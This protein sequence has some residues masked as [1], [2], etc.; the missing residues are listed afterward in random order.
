MPEGDAQMFGRYRLIRL[1]GA[2]GMATV[3][4]AQ[5]IGPQGFVKPCVLKRIAEP[6]VDDDKYR[7]MFL[8][9]ARLSAL[10]NHPNVVQTFDFGEVEG[11]PYMAMELVD[12]VNLSVLCRGLAK[13]N[14]WIPLRA[15][16]E[17]CIQV[18]EALFYA[19]NIVGLDGRSLNLVHRDVSPQNVLVSRQ[20]GVKLADFGIARHD[21]RIE[22]TMGPTSKG[23]PGY[24][25]PEQAM[26]HATDG[27]ADLFA[28]G[29]VLCELIS[30][31][32]VNK[33]SEAPV[34]IID[35]S[36]R[37]QTLCEIRTEAPKSLIDL[38]VR[39]SDI[40]T[41]KR[42]A[43]AREVAELLRAEAQGLPTKDGLAGF[44]HRV[45]DRYFPPEKL[46]TAFHGSSGSF[47]QLDE[48]DDAARLTKSVSGDVL[49]GTDDQRATMVVPVEEDHGKTT[50][51]EP[52]DSLLDA[53][54]VFPAGP[55]D[56][57][58]DVDVVRVMWTQMNMVEEQHPAAAYAGWPTDLR[59]V[60]APPAHAPAEP[61]REAR[62][63]RPDTTV[64][65]EAGS[66]AVPERHLSSLPSLQFEPT[67][68]SAAPLPTLPGQS[69][70]SAFAPAGETQLDIGD[71]VIQPVAAPVP[72]REPP[73]P[74]PQFD[75]E[76]APRRI[77]IAARTQPTG[78]FDDIAE[79][80]QDAIGDSGVMSKILIAIAVGIG[81][82]L[83]AGAWI[84]MQPK[85]GPISVAG[86]TVAVTSDPAGAEILINGVGEGRHTP[87]SIDG[88]PLE[89]PIKMSVRLKGYLPVPATMRVVI[90]AKLGR[91]DAHFQ[92]ETAHVF[93]IETTPPGAQVE[94]N[95]V[96][97]STRTPL[98]LPEVP[99]GGTATITVSLDQ[100][101]SVRRLLRVTANAPTVIVVP[102]EKA[103]V[104]EIASD[105]PGAKVFVDG[106][107]VGLTPAYDIPVPSVSAFEV[108]LAR[109]G[110]K[111]WKRDFIGAQLEEHRIE[112]E[113]LDVPL[114]SLPL[115]REERA[116]AR[117]LDQ[118]L[119]R[120]RAD[121]RKAKRVLTH[122]LEEVARLRSGD[123]SFV[124]PVVKAQSAA[125]EAQERVDHFEMELD[126]VQS[127]VESFR[128]KILLRIEQAQ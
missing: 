57:P 23:K 61:Q 114:L 9:E 126:A 15:A 49:E 46:P 8:Q 92:M 58:A 95:G 12:G 18:C 120:H 22:V 83:L 38:T 85:Q 119:A 69:D 26:G 42:P 50:V 16:V 80:L 35:V 53:P 43:H 104:I 25:A 52:Q 37:I 4:L 36:E 118:A 65:P 93:T 60:L 5:Q 116:R 124:A 106:R 33:G 59:P 3:H 87:S 82:T 44:L 110:F 122:R 68:P 40:D 10:L 77:E 123:H 17:I 128:E 6:F 111:Q 21:D 84:A 121:L 47:P 72:Q 100:H 102:L 55:N 13:M 45:F 127:E 48:P 125:D 113:L 2:G 76:R 101:L 56:G 79:R 91:T 51:D 90:P 19:H 98:D 39:L 54:T 70:A 62:G 89:V 32:R 86:G 20:G 64:D 1:V 73:A 31:R 81:I 7:R 107:E 30:A 112:G 75:V 96:L 41:S 66:G 108:R 27:R 74:A 11:V 88:L 67:S 94:M 109:E 63:A 29:I 99:M 24:M 115:D 34:S 14:R 105:P 97:L 71:D 28:V 78:P 117:R 103:H